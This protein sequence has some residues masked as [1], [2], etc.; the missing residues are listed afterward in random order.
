MADAT[1]VSYVPRSK[2]NRLRQ[3]LNTEDTRPVRWTEKR[4]LFGSEFFF[5]GPSAVVR[6]VH[7]HITS[8]LAEDR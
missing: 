6:R 5:S 4:G 2:R 8:W 7:A 1:Y 3:V